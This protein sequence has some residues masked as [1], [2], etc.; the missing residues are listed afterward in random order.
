MHLAIGQKHIKMLNNKISSM[1]LT[2]T[3]YIR[4]SDAIVND[5]INAEPSD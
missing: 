5:N 2:L 1:S 3:A 4:T